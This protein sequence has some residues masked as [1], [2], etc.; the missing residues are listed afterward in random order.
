MD[1]EDDVVKLKSAFRSKAPNPSNPKDFFNE[2]TINRFMNTMTTFIKRRK[3][4]RSDMI[5]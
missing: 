4:N 1:D 5:T 2:D 3:M